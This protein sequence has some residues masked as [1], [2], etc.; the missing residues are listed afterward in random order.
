MV[1]NGSLLDYL[2]SSDWYGHRWQ[3]GHCMFE[4][5]KGSSD[6]HGCEGTGRRLRLK[7]RGPRGTAPTAVWHATP[8]F[9]RQGDV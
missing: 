2:P 1:G 4:Q 6:W 7:V 8:P 3:N 9:A 5:T